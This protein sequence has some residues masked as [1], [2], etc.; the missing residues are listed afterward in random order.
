ME[1][2][3][4]MADLATAGFGLVAALAWNNA[5]Q[6]VFNYFLPQSGSIAI[7]IIYAI[8]I[9]IIV[10]L[11]TIKLGK[12]VNVAKEEVDENKP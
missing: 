2:L 4:K 3:A 1:I 9:T 12:L 5:I 6:S 8:L 10:V 11:I 7:Q